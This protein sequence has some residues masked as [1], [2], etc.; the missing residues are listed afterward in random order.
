MSKNSLL[1]NLSWKFAERISAQAVTMIVSVILAR[2]LQPSDYGIISIVMIFI[3]LANVFVS[4]GFGSALIQKKNADALDFSSVLYFNIGLSIVLYLALF[5]AAPYIT[6]FYGAGYEILTPVLRV[7]GLRIILCAINTVQNAYVSRKMIFRK[8]FYATLVGTVLS[9]AVGITLAFSGFGVWALVAQYMTNTMVN[10][11]FLGL[12]LKK[13]PLFSF[14]FSRL[15]GLVSYGWKILATNL[16]ITG[17]EE[18]K[19]LIIGKLYSSAD[20][21]CYDKGRQF[22]MLVITNVNASIGAVLFPKM[23]NEQNDIERLKRT[24]KNSVRFSSYIMFPLMIGLAAVAENFISVV[25]TDKWLACV[26]FLKMF[27]VV[28]LLQPLHSANMQA[29]KAVGRS[30]LLF[31]L[32]TVKK[33]I[34]LIVLLSVVWIS[35]EAIVISMALQSVLFS[36]INAYP[37]KK[38]LN[39]GIKEQIIDVAGPIWM[40]LLMMLAVSFVGKLQIPLIPLLCVQVLCGAVVYLILSIITKNSEFNYIINLL[41]S[42]L[43]ITKRSG[44]DV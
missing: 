18:L 27:C 44:K 30:D 6:R 43:K 8:F 24:A 3:T 40:S 41:K 2:L 39:Y 31:K 11:V 36:F 7:L 15:K 5:F 10:T 28:Y 14:S 19:A 23:S 21:A 13:K 4:D 9:A 17:Q 29:I 42:N 33:V 25:L 38:L 20:L 26:P 34:E 22:P 16:L 32:E 35:V 12:S 1:S 37:N